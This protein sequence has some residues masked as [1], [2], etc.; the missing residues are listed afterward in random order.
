M[1]SFLREIGTL[2]A[3]RA[4]PHEGEAICLSGMRQMFRTTGSF[5]E[6]STK[7]SFNDGPLSVPQQHSH[8]PGLPKIETH[9]LPMD[10]SGGLRTAPA[11]GSFPTDFSFPDLCF[12]QGN[13]INPAQLHF[14]GGSPGAGTNSPYQQMFSGMSA[15]QLMEE[16]NNYDWMS[17][18]DNTLSFANNE[19]A[20]DG[21]SPSAMSTNTPE[22]MNEGTMDASHLGITNV[23]VGRTPMWASAFGHFLRDGAGAG[24]G[25]LT[26]NPDRTRLYRGSEF[27]SHSNVTIVPSVSAQFASDFGTV[28]K[29]PD[30]QTQR[31]PSGVAG[32]GGCLIL[33]MAAIGAL[34]EFEFNDSKELFEASKKLLGGYLEARRRKTM[35]RAQYNQSEPDTTP[36][37]LVQAMLLNV[38]YGHNCGDKTSADI[39]SVHCAA[40]VSL[41]RAAELARPD[42][43]HEEDFLGE[44]EHFEDSDW[45]RWKKVE[46]RKRTLYGV[47]I[48]SSLLVSAYNHSPALTNSEIRLDIPCDET[49]WEADSAIKWK[50]LGG[51]ASAQANSISFAYALSHLLTASQRQPS[52]CHLGTAPFGSGVGSDSINFS[53]LKPSTFGCLILINALHNYIWETRQRHL[54]PIWTKEE[55]DQM[56]AHIE[57]ALRA[58]Q[59]AWSSNPAHS[60]ERPNPFGLGPLSADSIPLLDLAYVRLFVNLGRS[61]EAFWQR[62]WDAMAN[63]LA[64]GTEII[65]HAEQMSPEGMGDAKPEHMNGHDEPHHI[66]MLEPDLGLLD[67]PSHEQPNGG[68]VHLSGHINH[69]GHATRRER[70]LRKA[71]FYA[72]DS[73]SHSDKLGISLAEHTSRELPLQSAL[74]AFDCAQVLAEWITTV[75]ERVGRYIGIIGQDNIDLGQIPA[76]MLL[77]EEDIKLIEKIREVLQSAEM[78]MTSASLSM[79]GFQVADVSSGEGGYGSKILIVTANMLERAAVWPVTKLMARCLETQAAHMKDRA[80]NSIMGIS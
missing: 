1:H 15:T 62:D 72:A 16:E 26:Q 17:G 29:T 55:T 21:S 66:S 12:D 47:F 60:P 4:I 2:E 13:T 78:K 6:T 54:G 74:C 14:G 79:Q 80:N 28:V 63:E 70:H 53:D 71:A 33:A 30:G 9:G 43:I 37:W 35:N 23:S 52:F 59:A 41:A 51:Q 45:V 44:D 56:H 5:I 34:Y 77:E 46:E 68:Q 31:G 65:Q 8:V 22:G 24:G 18:F 40:L 38:I 42:A 50:S 57:P 49:L 39:A 64:C 3:P 61:K 25:H 10:M 67:A 73:L 75:Q 69:T 48:L 27:L 58:W 20:I 76:I 11:F 32:G 36:L 19:N 7:T